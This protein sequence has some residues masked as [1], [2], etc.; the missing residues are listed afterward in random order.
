VA[1]CQ[2]LRQFRKSSQCEKRICFFSSNC[3]NQSAIC[4]NLGKRWPNVRFFGNFEKAANAKS[5]FA[6]FPP[7]ARTRT[8]FASTLVNGGQMSGSSA[9]SQK[10]P[11]RKAHSLLFLQLLEPERHLPQPLAVIFKLEDDRFF[12]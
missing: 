2:V 8:P 1:K 11:M 3:S 7:I 9:I 5:A 12:P 4:L 10:Q 6:S